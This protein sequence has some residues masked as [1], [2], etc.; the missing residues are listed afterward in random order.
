[1]LFVYR[2]FA[3]KLMLEALA[4]TLSVAA[5]SWHL[6]ERYALELESTIPVVRQHH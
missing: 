1:M 6:I 5:L 3:I 2:V 4:S